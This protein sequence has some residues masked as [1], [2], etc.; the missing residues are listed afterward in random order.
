[1][2]R[3]MRDH[4]RYID[5][6]QCAAARVVAALRKRARERNATNTQGHFDTMHIR[7]G[8]F[9]YKMTRVDATE[10]YKVTKRVFAEG[11]TV[12]IATDERDKSFFQFL[13]DHYDVVFMD[14]Y[15]ED[16]GDVNTNYVSQSASHVNAIFKS[17]V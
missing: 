4:M 5:E 8:D 15:L 12:Y 1:M 13:S 14:D 16:L 7:R 9:Q 17:V 2:K 10:I 3:F 6:I 11:S